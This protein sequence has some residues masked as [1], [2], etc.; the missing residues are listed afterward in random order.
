M[1]RLKRRASGDLALQSES[2]E[3]R[4]SCVYF[5]SFDR[6]ALL[7]IQAVRRSIAQNR[8]L[9]SADVAPIV[10]E[11]CAA[12]HRPTTSRRFRSDYEDA[13]PFK[14]AIKQKVAAREMPPRHADPHYGESQRGAPHATGDRYDRQLDFAGSETRRPKDLPELP[15]KLTDWEIGKPD[16][17]LTMTQA[18]GAGASPD[19]YVYVTFLTKFKEDK[20]CRRRDC[21]GNKRVVHHVIA[22]AAASAN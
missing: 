6:N 21:P 5:C 7:L 16:Y 12:C 3:T 9:L 2:Y 8:E 15:K 14:D 17:V 20:W 11:H 4:L 19:A 1:S 18:H 22:H 13:L 10:Y